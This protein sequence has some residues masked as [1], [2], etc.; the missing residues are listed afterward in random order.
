M[1]A[2]DSA[3][4]ASAMVSSCASL[5]TPR[6]GCSAST[7]RS[8]IDASTPFGASTLTLS[9][10][11]LI[12][13]AAGARAGA[14]GGCGCSGCGAAA[15]AQRCGPLAQVPCAAGGADGGRPRRHGRRGAAPRCA[16]GVL[17]AVPLRLR[18]GR[19]WKCPARSGTVPNLRALPLADE[20]SV[21]A[22]GALFWPS[23]ATCFSRRWRPPAAPAPDR[24]GACGTQTARLTQ[25]TVLHARS[26]RRATP[27]RQPRCVTPPGRHRGIHRRACVSGSSDAPA[28]SALCLCLVVRAAVAPALA[29]QQ[30]RL[31]IL[32]VLLLAAT[33]VGQPQVLLRAA[34]LRAVAARALFA[35]GHAFAIKGAVRAAEREASLAEHRLKFA[36]AQFARARVAVVAGK[37]CSPRR[38]C[39]A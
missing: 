32:P 11:R 27:V 35:H 17:Q 23:G 22:L 34:S 14:T 10:G 7:L 2:S 25:A 38:S 31:V 24:N 9:P 18:A 19:A 20:A 30:A 1:L 16:A 28:S 12:L 8:E 29:A 21:R 6:S 39:G 5:I 33:R 15:G 36:L 13:S 4:S 3:R 26:L 37:T